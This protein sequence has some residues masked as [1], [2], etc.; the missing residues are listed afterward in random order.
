MKRLLSAAL[1]AAM[2]FGTASFAADRPV[3]PE[4]GQARSGQD[5]SGPRDGEPDSPDNGIEITPP[6]LTENGFMPAPDSC[7]FWWRCQ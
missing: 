4:T 1:I 6:V 3:G 2:A 7:W 5:G